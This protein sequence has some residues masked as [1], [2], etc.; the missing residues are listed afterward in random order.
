MA[1][2]T[3]INP[4]IESSDFMCAASSPPVVQLE[5]T[6]ALNTPYNAIGAA[7]AINHNWLS[8]KI[9]SCRTKKPTVAITTGSKTGLRR[10][11]AK[12]L[13]NMFEDRP[14]NLGFMQLWFLKL[15][16]RR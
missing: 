10:T 2:S 15:P 5:N 12:G 8:S 16:T 7:T 4:K 13:T 1:R 14:S 3:P 9:V 11:T 6:A